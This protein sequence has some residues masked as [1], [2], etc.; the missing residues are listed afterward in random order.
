MFRKPP[1]TLEPAMVAA[2]ANVAAVD[3]V[4]AADFT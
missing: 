2:F 1:R 3:N 4:I